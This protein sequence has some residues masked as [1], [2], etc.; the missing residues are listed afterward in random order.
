MAPRTLTRDPV[1]SA[2]V[3]DRRTLGTSYPLRRPRRAFAPSHPVAEVNPRVRRTD[4]TPLLRLR[5]A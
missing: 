5:S 4:K 2:Y 3:I 1:L